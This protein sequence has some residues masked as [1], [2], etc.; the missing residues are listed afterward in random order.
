MKPFKL[1]QGNSNNISKFEDDIAQAIEDGYELG[2]EIISKVIENPN[3][4]VEILFF[5]PMTIEEHLD[6]DD[7]DLDYP[8]ND[9]E[10]TEA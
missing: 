10:E 8:D 3:K 1:I 6:F 7:E 2:G 9:E 5:Q 4:S